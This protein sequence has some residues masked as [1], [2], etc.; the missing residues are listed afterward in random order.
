MLKVLEN[1]EEAIAKAKSIDKG[2]QELTILD[3]L[4]LIE[5]SKQDLL[6]ATIHAYNI[7]FMQGLEAQKKD[8]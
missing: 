1:V 3:L 4:D 5:A 2:D 7:G 8:V 6:V